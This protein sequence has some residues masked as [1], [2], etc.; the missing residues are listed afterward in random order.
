MKKL[1]EWEK[2][3]HWFSNSCL[4]S[5]KNKIAELIKNKQIIK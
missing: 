4:N 3:I 1:N 5:Q 2:T